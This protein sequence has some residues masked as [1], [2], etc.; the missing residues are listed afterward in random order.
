MSKLALPCIVCGK[1]L[2]NV[3][4]DIDN[5]PYVGT[6]FQSMGHDG[7]TIHDPISEDYP[8]FLVV[9]IC[10]T[11]V[12]RAIKAGTIQSR[13]DEIVLSRHPIGKR[14]EAWVLAQNYKKYGAAYGDD[15]VVDYDALMIEAG[16]DISEEGE[17]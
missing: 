6:E 17:E 5:Q 16:W 1:P 10:D 14:E 12:L 4:E 7:S 11:C 9:N 8:L 3:G 13:N 15:E 2:E